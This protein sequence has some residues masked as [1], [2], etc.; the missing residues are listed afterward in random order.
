MNEGMTTDTTEAPQHAARRGTLEEAESAASSSSSSIA[1]QAKDSEVIEEGILSSD[2]E[3]TETKP[4]PK[5]GDR[6]LA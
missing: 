1:G 6:P 2:E 5:V 3:A 4:A